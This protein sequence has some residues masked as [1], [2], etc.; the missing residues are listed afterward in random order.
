MGIG[1]GVTGDPGE[2]WV[3]ICLRAADQ[4][5]GKPEC[6]RGLHEGEIQAAERGAPACGDH[7]MQGIGRPQGR[8][9]VA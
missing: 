1:S 8:C 4:P 9:P 6:L 2:A 3:A 5:G 7:Q